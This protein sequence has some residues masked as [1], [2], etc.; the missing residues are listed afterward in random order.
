MGRELS[1]NNDFNVHRVFQKTSIVPSSIP[2]HNSLPPPVARHA[3]STDEELNAQF[4][5]TT[6]ATFLA[7]VIN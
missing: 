4:L 7:V 1:L 2:K 3:K 6:W 5:L